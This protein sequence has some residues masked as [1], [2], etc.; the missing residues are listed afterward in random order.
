MRERTRVVAIIR[1]ASA[2]EWLTAHAIRSMS[3]P[4]F[5]ALGVPLPGEAD[6]FRHLLGC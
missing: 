3:L 5:Q 1:I 2:V 6:R 4:F